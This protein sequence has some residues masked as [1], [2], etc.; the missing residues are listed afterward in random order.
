MLSYNYLTKETFTQS[1]PCMRQVIEDLVGDI[2]SPFTKNTTGKRVTYISTTSSCLKNN[3]TSLDIESTS[4]R[5]DGNTLRSMI[6]LKR[7][8]VESLKPEIAKNRKHVEYI[9]YLSITSIYHIGV[10]YLVRPFWNNTSNSWTYRIIEKSPLH[11]KSYPLLI[12]QKKFIV[13]EQITS[14]WILTWD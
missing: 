13:K 1:S 11:E 10:D 14:I 3:S 5:S 8:F 9:M 2:K 4:F 7:L 12:V 6:W